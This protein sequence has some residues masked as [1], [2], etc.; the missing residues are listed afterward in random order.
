M[1]INYTHNQKI[2]NDRNNLRNKSFFPILKSFLLQT[3]MPLKLIQ[4]LF[5]LLKRKHIISNYI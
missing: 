1:K 4:L 2:I 3:L 5:H